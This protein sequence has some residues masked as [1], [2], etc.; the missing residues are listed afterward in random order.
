MGKVASHTVILLTMT[1]DSQGNLR[2]PTTQ[3]QYDL[4]QGTDAHL[5]LHHVQPISLP[6]FQSLLF[7][8]QLNHVLYLPL[9]TLS[10]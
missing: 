4:G 8:N 1:G 5:V 3:I 2:V 10:F 9:K 6:R 7:H